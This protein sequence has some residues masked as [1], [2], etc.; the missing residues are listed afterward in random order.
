M[1]AMASPLSRSTGWVSSYEAVARAR[2]LG[3]TGALFPG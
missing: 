2:Q 1:T 3:R